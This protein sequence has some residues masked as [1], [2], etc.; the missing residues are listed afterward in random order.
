[1][2]TAAFGR[3]TIGCAG[4]LSLRVHPDGDRPDQEE[5]GVS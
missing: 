1:M 2:L 3:T 4:A 5:H